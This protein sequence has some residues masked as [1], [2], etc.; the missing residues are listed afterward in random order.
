[1][2]ARARVAA[3][4]LIAL[5]PAAALS[6]PAEGLAPPLAGLAGVFAPPD[7]TAAYTCTFHWFRTADGRIVGMDV[8]RS[9]DTGRLGL[10][11]FLAGSDGSLRALIHEAPAAEWEPFASEAPPAA[12][13]ER[14]ALGRGRGWVAARVRGAGPSI[15]EA[16]F[17]LEVTPL[18][19]GCTAG[20]F[21]L[22]FVDLSATDF[23]RVRTRGRLV[24]DGEALEIDAE[25][26]CSIH[27]GRALPDYG[28]LA[29]VPGSE[30][31]PGLLLAS[32]RGDNLRKGQALAGER[33]FTYAHF[34]DL[35][36]DL[37]HLKFVSLRRLTPGAASYH[38]PVLGVP[39]FGKTV[40]VRRVLA[41]VPHTL[42]G[43]PTTTFLAEVELS[44][45]RL[46]PPL[47][48]ERHRVLAIGDVRGEYYQEHVGAGAP[49][50]GPAAGQAGKGL[51]GSL[52]D[53]AQ[54]E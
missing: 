24:V 25:G 22:D 2:I 18:G 31:G 42:L 48:R 30:P 52:A 34:L 49:E 54:D 10:R 28:Y 19:P 16:S 15:R 36:G 44:V 7:A 6:Q 43:R 12:T 21:G 4:A 26:P 23:P 13:G 27:Y 40:T 3:L 9:G 53:S 33:A 47:K 50:G 1:M 45:P 37:P 8:V 14:N 38:F 20:D 29:T 39:A 11:L 46:W 41:S 32:T 35:P 17:Q 5:H 51:A